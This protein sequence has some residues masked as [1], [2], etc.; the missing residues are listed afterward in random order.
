MVHPIGGGDAV[1]LPDF[2]VIFNSFKYFIFVQALELSPWIFYLSVE[3]KGIAQ[4][5]GIA[6]I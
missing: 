2:E 3:Q 4:K 1:V 6:E 5:R